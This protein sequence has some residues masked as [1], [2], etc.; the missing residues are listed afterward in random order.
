MILDPRTPVLV[1][2]GQVTNRPDPGVAVDERPD[3][4]ALMV[5][6]LE[7][8][9]EDCDGT[10]PGGPASV[11]RRLLQRAGSLRTM[12]ILTWRIP[13]P[14]LAVAAALGIEPAEQV[15]T[16]VG[17][18]M[19][20]TL[21]H[22]TARTI[23]RGDL[24]VAVIAGAECAYTQH[25]ARR[26]PGGQALHWPT[27][28]DATTPRPLAFGED[29]SPATDQEAARGILLPIHAYPLLEN[30]LR[31]ANG[32][33]LGE[34]R[35]RFGGLWSRFSDVA[36]QN[37]YAWLPRARTPDEI[38]RPG[39]GNRPVAFPYPKLCTA[40]LQ[41]DQGAALICCSVE[42]ARAAGVP[43][44]RWVFP[45]SGT[46]GHDHWFLSERPRL[47]RSPAIRLA[48]QRALALA[49]VGIDDI[50]A[51]DLYSCFPCAVQISATELGLAPD[52]PSRPLTVT[53]GLT[54]AGG[55][56]NNYT[57]HGIA[58]MVT[59]LRDAPGTV[60]LVTGLGWYATK[61]AVGIYASRPPAHGGGDGFRWED[62]QGVVD[63]EPTCPVDTGATGP[64][65]VETYT[66]VYDRDGAP[67][68]G[69]FAC[70]TAAGA[71][72][73]AGSTDGAALAEIAVGEGIGRTGT[74]DA[75]GVVDLA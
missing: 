51:V 73:W 7:A 35:A 11:G 1:G 41:V 60:G 27:Q 70:R 69:I 56:G 8:A 17:G 21:L 42:A 46:D 64:V 37:Q 32:W 57:T 45:L 12:G 50:D 67:E 13:N 63:A 39:P 53:G 9:A 24:D 44:E 55:P 62:V 58:T 15:L 18:N 4:V 59:R 71:R 2:V 43:E 68:R 26:S 38:T 61:H 10:P 25:A 34:H 3:P 48:G 6:A 52:D 75:A 54:F 30:A 5:R 65:T 31:G 72:T 40:N 74:L 20:Q 16:A 47:D 22:D 49:E 66:V 28:P 29:R 14:G 23:A 19:P 33:T 36:A